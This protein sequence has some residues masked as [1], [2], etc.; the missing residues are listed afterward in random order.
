MRFHRNRQSPW[1]E[2][3][4]S[5]FRS[6][7]PITIATVLIRLIGIGNRWSS[8]LFQSAIEDRN[9]NVLS[10]LKS[11]DFLIRLQHWT[12]SHSKQFYEP[13]HPC[14][15]VIG[16]NNWTLSP[17]RCD[18]V[19]RPMNSQNQY[20]YISILLKDFTKWFAPVFYVNDCSIHNFKIHQLCI[21][22]GNFHS[23]KQ[24]HTVRHRFKQLHKK[25]QSKLHRPIIKTCTQ[26]L[27]HL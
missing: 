22:Y 4:F 10:P 24:N 5:K 14:S 8:E 6:S 12:R 9:C 15:L 20:I 7:N 1:F 25:N 3:L 2:Y 27:F 18:G 19:Y 13:S 26:Y 11:S 17:I 16:C 23:L 21:N